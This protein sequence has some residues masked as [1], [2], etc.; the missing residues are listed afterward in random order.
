MNGWGSRML[1]TLTLFTCYCSVCIF[2]PPPHLVVP[3]M[4]S[5]LLCPVIAFSLYFTWKKVPFCLV[6]SSPHLLD[7]NQSH[8]LYRSCIWFIPFSLLSLFCVLT[9]LEMRK[10]NKKK[11]QCCTCEDFWVKNVKKRKSRGPALTTF[12]LTEHKPPIYSTF[13]DCISPFCHWNLT[14]FAIFSTSSHCPCRLIWWF[15]GQSFEFYHF[16]I[17][18]WTSATFG[19]VEK[20][21]KHKH[22]RQVYITES[23]RWS[24]NTDVL[25]AVERCEI[26]V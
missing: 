24:N 23:T 21:T 2:F 20:K 16:I 19:K 11:F 13:H 9:L 25:T 1:H 8:S 22:N 5:Y 4:S 6:W 3:S 14:F 12:E 15:T 26:L 18:P 10:V 17:N 7:S